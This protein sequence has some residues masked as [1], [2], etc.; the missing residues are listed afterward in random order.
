VLSLEQ[1]QIFELYKHPRYAGEVTSPDLVAEGINESCGDEVR[2]TMRLAGET[3]A[4]I[5]HVTRGC[6]I[7]TAA[8]DLLAARLEGKSV[9]CLGELSNNDISSELG[10]PLSPVRLKCALLPL[11]TLRQAQKDRP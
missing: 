10:I 7:C 2:F 11:E 5:R 9:A 3:F 6:A 8:A 1:Q 4:E